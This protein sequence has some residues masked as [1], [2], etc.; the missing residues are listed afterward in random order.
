MMTDTAYHLADTDAPA[1]TGVRPQSERPLEL[2]GQLAE[3]GLN[4]ALAL[5]RQ[6][7]GKLAPDETPIAADVCAAYERV[8]KAVR[9]TILLQ[10]KVIADLRHGDGMARLQRQR[11]EAKADQARQPRKDAGRDRIE[12]IVARGIDAG[13]EDQETYDRLHTEAVERLEH[14]D[15][16]GTVL[17]RPM[18]EIVADICQDLGIEPPWSGLAEEAWA[19][20]EISSGTVGWPL[21]QAL[22]AE[23]SPEPRTPSAAAAAPLLDAPQPTPARPGPDPARPEADPPSA[24]DPASALPP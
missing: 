1:E 16:Y 6:A 7:T 4:I 10:S 22:A 13:A 9:M 19:M 3:I 18:S 5:E 21:A 20:E 11:D 14:E 2:L 17:T 12:A 23:P 8:A 15:I 24:H